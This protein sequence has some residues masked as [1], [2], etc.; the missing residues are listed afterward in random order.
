MTDERCPLCGYN[1]S[2]TYDEDHDLT[3]CSNCGNIRNRNGWGKTLHKCPTCDERPRN[4]VAE[5]QVRCCGVIAADYAA[6]EAYGEAYQCAWDITEFG[7][8]HSHEQWYQAHQWHELIDQ[9]EKFPQPPEVD[10]SG[11]TDRDRDVVE[12]LHAAHAMVHYQ[13]RATA[14]VAR[15][16]E[17]GIPAPSELVYAQIRQRYWDRL[18]WVMDPMRPPRRPAHWESR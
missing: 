9:L 15:N 3:T 12:L 16:K 2:A 14:Q 11:G 4:H 6:W 1:D 5:G 17:R 10:A 13:D 8:P 18:F 7:A